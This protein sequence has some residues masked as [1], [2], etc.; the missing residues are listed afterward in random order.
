MIHPITVWRVIQLPRVIGLLY[1][2]KYDE[3]G[4]R[5]VIVDRG[6]RTLPEVPKV[7]LVLVRVIP[8]AVSGFIIRVLK[9]LFV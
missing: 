6:A 5:R 3:L 1:N 2:L 8:E 7:I 4:V 9:M